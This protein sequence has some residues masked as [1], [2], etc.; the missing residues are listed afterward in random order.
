MD[1]YTERKE[2][3][4]SLVLSLAKTDEEVRAAQRL[5]YNVFAL[6]CGA[7]LDS[8]EPGIDCDELDSYCD[9]LLVKDATSEQVVGTYRILTP[10]KA[11]E[12]GTYYSESEFDLR[13]LVPIMSTMVE[14]GRSCIHRDFRHGAAISLLWSGL[15]HYMMTRGY[16]YLIGCA[17]VQLD[18]G[19]ETACATYSSLRERCLSPDHWRVFPKNPYP[20]TSTESS[21]PVPLPP[22]I[23][24]YVRLGAYVCGEPAW[25]QRFNSADLL[26]LLPLS[27]INPRYARHFLG[28]PCL[29]NAQGL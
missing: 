10:W 13:N 2:G 24:G 25:D 7:T 1:G 23:K 8:P 9:H 14:V 26:M 28:A 22:L 19:G 29:S 17:S 21:E 20:L 15:A 5:R 18:D 4:K 3:P 6:E 11:K 27:R 16:E 12:Y